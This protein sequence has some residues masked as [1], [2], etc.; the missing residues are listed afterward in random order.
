MFYETLPFDD[1]GGMNGGLEMVFRFETT[2]ANVVDS[3]FRETLAKLQL[4]AV[5]V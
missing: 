4:S 2:L 5:R 1:Q 3:D